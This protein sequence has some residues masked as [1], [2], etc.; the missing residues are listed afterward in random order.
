MAARTLAAAAI[1]RTNVLAN[2][3]PE[4]MPADGSAHLDRDRVAHSIV[5]YEMHRRAIE[6]LGFDH[7]AP[8]GTH[9]YTSC[10]FHH[11]IRRG[12]FDVTQRNL[13][14]RDRHDYAE[15]SHEPIFIIS[16]TYSW[17]DQPSPAYFRG[18]RSTIGRCPRK[19]R[20]ERLENLLAQSADQRFEFSSNIFCDNRHPRPYREIH[21]L[22]LPAGL[23][24]SGG[25]H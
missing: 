8:S 5:K 15:K 13:P 11:Q 24:C 2:V 21:P 23:A 3:A 22:V 4:H 14:N 16:S 12:S 18:D 7:G 20:I 1:P 25:F 10:S 17:R 19:R 9:R 6:N